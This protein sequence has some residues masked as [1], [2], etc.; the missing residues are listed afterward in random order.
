MP[1]GRPHACADFELSPSLPLPLALLG[2]S[3]PRPTVLSAV[4]ATFKLSCD[5]IV[6]PRDD[7][8]A[9]MDPANQ[10]SSILSASCSES[11]I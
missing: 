9:G 10:T 7:H 11:P 8:L 1:I 3:C 5:R 2:P 4:S 6:G